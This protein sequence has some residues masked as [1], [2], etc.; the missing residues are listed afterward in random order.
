MPAPGDYSCVLACEDLGAEL[1]RPPLAAVRF[2]RASGFKLSLRAWAELPVDVRWAIAKEGARDQVD[3]HIART[4]MRHVPMRH[5][6]LIGDTNVPDHLPLPGVVEVLGVRETWVDRD[7][8]QLRPFHRFVLNV[9][10]NNRRLMWRAFA[11][12]EGV[13]VSRNDGWHGPVAHAEVEIRAADPV[14]GELLSLLATEKLLEG[15]ALLLARASGLRVAR[16]SADVFDLYADRT[17]GPIELDWSV[18]VPSATVLWQ[19]HVSTHVGDF[20]PVASLAAVAASAVCLADMLKE[21]DPQVRVREVRIVEE[22]WSVGKFE[23]EAATTVF[24]GT[25]VLPR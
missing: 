11:E 4:L 21:F 1:D 15:R 6:E 18:E 12:I 24:N 23:A 14:R 20:F 5:V 19:A 8:P 3:Q 10:R 7:W 9:L 17:P 13:G 22:E 16:A 2:F 25:L